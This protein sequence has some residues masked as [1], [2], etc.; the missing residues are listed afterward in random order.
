MSMVTLQSL[1]HIKNWNFLT[2]EEKSG[3]LKIKKSQIK[4]LVLYQSPISAVFPIVRFAGDQKTA[5]TRES[6]YKDGSWPLQNKILV[7]FETWGKD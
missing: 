1:F 7:D 2:N 5:L 3:T 6:L 4:I